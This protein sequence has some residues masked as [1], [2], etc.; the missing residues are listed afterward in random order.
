V[1]CDEWACIVCWVLYIWQYSGVTADKK[2]TRLVIR[3]EEARK[4]G[5]C[6]YL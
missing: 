4:K 1:V 2:K 3:N 6:V 5:S